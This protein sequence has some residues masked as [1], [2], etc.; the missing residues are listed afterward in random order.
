MKEFKDIR[1]IIFDYDGTLHNS[2]KIYTIAFREAYKYLVE[3]EQATVVEWKDEE[4]SIWVGL[5]AK[6]M[7]ESFMPNLPEV[8]KQKCSQII[9]ATMVKLINEGEA[10]LY[11]GVI[12]VLEYL[13]NKGLNLIF[14]SNCKVEYMNKHIQKFNLDKYFN[15]FYC[16]EQFM[17]IPKYEIFKE[18]KKEHKGDFVIIGDRYLDIE[19]G[20]IHNEKTIGCSYGYGSSTE[21]EKAD[22]RINNITD[23]LDLF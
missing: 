9:G 17:F 18:I 6:D 13:K 12:E 16:T 20:L 19:I 23:L 14:L 3:T 7:W 15:D 21:L 8:E 5:S 10:E 1:N 22:F 11:Q 2:L 4:I